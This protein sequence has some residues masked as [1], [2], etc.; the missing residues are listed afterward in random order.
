M[1]FRLR[2]RREKGAE[3]FDINDC[4]EVKEERKQEFHSLQKNISQ[5]QYSNQAFTK[6]AF[7]LHL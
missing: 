7:P 3:K 5:L 2:L 4:K 6:S 1:G